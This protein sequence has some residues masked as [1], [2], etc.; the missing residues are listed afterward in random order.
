MAQSSVVVP[1]P[2]LERLSTYLRYLLELERAGVE[3][4]RSAEIE[5]PTGI[6]AAQFRK[7]LSY[8]GEF[9]K[10]GSGY[11]VSE[12]RARIATILKLDR[13]QL[14][15]LVG[16][17]NLGAALAAFPVWA[18]YHLHIAAVFD[19]NIAKIGRRLWDW[20]ILDIERVA[21]VNEKL[22]AE[23]G[24]IAVPAEAAQ[25]VADRLVSA[26]V[27]GLLNFAPASIRHAPGVAIRNVSLVQ[28][29]AVLTYQL[30]DHTGNRLPDEAPQE[31]EAQAE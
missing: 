21:E 5:E 13:D 30:G 14:V 12:L 6:S 8:F 10:P 18:Q 11:Y 3:T 2:T 15:L 17:G 23:I 27:R 7:D 16:A 20:E 9:G 28:E 4:I 24:I 26:G 1:T 22:G 29:M 19:N 25:S 31:D